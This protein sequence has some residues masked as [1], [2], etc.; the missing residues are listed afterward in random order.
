MSA[1]DG[2]LRPRSFAVLAAAA[3]LS[4]A[5]ASPP[6]AETPSVRPAAR[7]MKMDEPMSG[8]MMKDG[9]TK[10]DMRQA[11]ERKAKTM[12]PMMDAD[13]KAMPAPAK[14]P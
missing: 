12:K 5:A 13:E 6:P 2:I 14:T 11:A 3:I 4:V 7:P 9:M 8:G 1:G 10:G